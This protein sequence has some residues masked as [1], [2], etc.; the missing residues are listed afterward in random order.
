MSTTT[1]GDGPVHSYVVTHV[2]GN[3]EVELGLTKRELFAAMAIQGLLSNGRFTDAT[4]E[5][6]SDE[7]NEAYTGSLAVEI[8]DAL[9]EALNEEKA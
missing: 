8:A 5:Q 3:V 7:N 9:I 4:N 1:A 2:A 6:V